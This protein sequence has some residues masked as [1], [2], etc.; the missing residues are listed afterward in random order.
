VP[1][2]NIK[3]LSLLELLVV[4]ALIGIVTAVA[5]PNFNEWNR[6]RL[7]RNGADRVLAFMKNIHSQ[8]ERGTFAYVQVLI[9]DNGDELILTSKGMTMQDLTDKIHDGGSDWNDDQ[10][11]RCDIGKA[12]YWSTDTAGDGA[13]IKNYV[14]EIELEGV[15]TTFSETTAVC[16]ARNGKFFEAAAD[17]H[18]DSGVDA[19]PYQYLYICRRGGEACEIPTADLTVKSKPNGDIKHLRAINF[20]RFGN[21]SISKFKPEYDTDREYDKDGSTWMN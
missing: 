8:T 15:T 2:K 3:G 11:S 20:G 6:E 17:T 10:N 7:V 9:T 14:F 1:E 16:F 5:Y 18:L 12:D 19:V 13:D 21:F 4:L